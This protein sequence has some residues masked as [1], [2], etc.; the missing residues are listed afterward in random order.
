MSVIRKLR[1]S[2][3]ESH[4]A[5]KWTG[6]ILTFDEFCESNHFKHIIPYSA[7]DYNALPKDKQRDLKDVGGYVFGQLDETGKRKKEHLLTREGLTYDLDGINKGQFRNIKTKLTESNLNHLIHSTASYDGVNIKIRVVVP[8]YYSIKPYDYEEI[9]KTFAP[10]AGIP[11][12]DDVCSFEDTHLFYWGTKLKDIEPI[13]QSVTNKAFL[14]PKALMKVHAQINPIEVITIP[15]KDTKIS[16]IDAIDTIK[17]YVA[18][19]KQHLQNREHYVSAKMMLVKSIQA[20]DIDKETAIECIKLL[21]CGNAEWESNNVKELNAEIRSNIRPKIDGD[22]FSKFNFKVVTK[23][24]KKEAKAF[25]ANDIMKS[26]FDPIK[27]YIETM[28]PEGAGWLAGDPKTGKSFFAMQMAVAIANGEPFLG[29][30]TEQ[31]NVIYY[32][33]E[34]VPQLIKERFKIMYYNKGLPDNLFFYFELPN[35]SYG[36]IEKIQEHM[37]LHDAK[38]VIVDTYGLISMEKSNNKPLYEQTYKEIVPFRQLAEKKRA[39]IILVTHLNK[40]KQGIDDFARMMGSVAN[41]GASDFNMVLAK[42]PKEKEQRHFREESR[43]SSGLELVLRQEANAIFTLLGSINQIEAHRKKEAYLSNPIASIIKY[44]LLSQS[45]LTISP[46][47]LYEMLPDWAKEFDVSGLGTKINKLQ[48]DLNKYDRITFIKNRAK[49]GVIYIFERPKNIFSFTEIRIKPNE[50]SVEPT[51]NEI[52]KNEKKLS[53]KTL[54]P[55][56]PT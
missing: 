2:V 29:Y 38:V 45:K 25:S 36:G 11:L 21:A 9:A 22:F 33:L 27:F 16:R 34:M 51:P 54:L 37:E 7:L 24:E 41:R 48:Y 23:K 19:E 8:F 40:D 55:Y 6:K 17:Q 56:T 43:K 39:S 14:D 1:I 13:Y 52:E 53:Y 35:V 30:K 10:L 47:K 32:S 26:N 44:L 42:D 28:L 15:R 20:G 5:T 12:D 18:K 46:T 4:K 50:N 49:K 31:A 3:A